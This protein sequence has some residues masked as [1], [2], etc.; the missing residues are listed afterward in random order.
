[1]VHLFQ[2]VLNFLYVCQ[3]VIWLTFLLKLHKYWDIS[4]SGWDIFLKFFGDIPGMLVHLF[5]IILNFCMS[6]S[7][8]FS[9]LSYWNYTN[10][11]ICPWADR[12]NLTINLQQQR[13]CP[14]QDQSSRT[15][16]CWCA[17]CWGLIR[18]PWLSGWE[19]MQGTFWNK[20]QPPFS[21]SSA[22][23]PVVFVKWTKSI[24]WS[25]MVSTTYS[26]TSSE[27]HTQLIIKYS[28]E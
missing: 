27:A 6:L 3:S 9:S 20:N 11:G 23:I 19:T 7:L 12:V 13:C 4:S 16:L 8:L 22:I 25:G 24:S 10:I 2:I 15:S 14:Y 5:K 28:Y 18:W 26:W 17:G 1:M 21:K